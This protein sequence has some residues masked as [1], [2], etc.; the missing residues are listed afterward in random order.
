VLL[1]LKKA[2]GGRSGE[3]R[4]SAISQNEQASRFDMM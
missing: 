4:A 1:V 3:G 2:L